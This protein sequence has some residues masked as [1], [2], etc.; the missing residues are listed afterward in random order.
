MEAFVPEGEPLVL[1]VDETLERR[2]GK[3][4][5]AEGIYRDP[6]R[7]R[8]ANTSSK[9]A[10]SDGCACGA[11]G[12]DP[13]GASGVWSLPFSSVLKAFQEVRKRPGF[14]THRHCS[15]QAIRR[16]APAL[17]GLFCVVALLLPTAKGG[18]SRRP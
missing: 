5:P 6:V 16:S 14:E 13:L 12:A 18:G 15:E 1:G 3:K 7:S 2:R 17:L 4:I 8:A 10:P 9:P 11:F